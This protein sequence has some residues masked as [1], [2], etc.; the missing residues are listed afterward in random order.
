MFPV[1]A[2]SPS[3][4]VSRKEMEITMSALSRK[5]EFAQTASVSSVV[6]FKLFVLAYN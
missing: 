1:F 6:A 2:G 3:E 5:P 4:T